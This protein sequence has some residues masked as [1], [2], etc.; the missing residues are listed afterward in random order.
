MHVLLDN[1]E[2]TGEIVDGMAVPFKALVAM[3]NAN[4]KDWILNFSATHIKMIHSH[5]LLF[6]SFD[7]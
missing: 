3:S 4:V 6:M 1:V 5:F 7:Q 2:N